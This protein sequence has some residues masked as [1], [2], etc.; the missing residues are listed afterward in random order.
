M[1]LTNI[2]PSFGLAL[3]LVGLP[4]PAMAQI[5]G[6]RMLDTQP[7]LNPVENVVR[8]V[9]REVERQLEKEVLPG[10]EPNAVVEEVT[11]VLDPLAELP[12]Q[13][14]ILNL[15]GAQVFVD[16]EVEDGWRAVERQWLVMLE[17]GELALLQ[18]LDIEILEQTQ[19]DGLGLSLLR[20]RVADDL[21]SREALRQVLPTNLVDRFDRNHIYNPQA[22]KD[23]AQQQDSLISSLCE[24]SLKVGMIDTAIQ[25]QHPAFKHSRITEHNFLGEEFDQPNGHGTAVAGLLVGSDHDSPARLPQATLYNASVFYTRSQYAQG[26]TMMHLVSGL[27]WLMQEDVSVINMS[28]A[29]P[30]NQI[31]AAVV[32]RVSSRGKVIVAAAGNEGPA[33]PPLYPAAYP[34]VISATAVDSE[35]KIYRWANRGDHVDFAAIGVSVLTARGDGKFGRESGTSMAAPVVSAF[36]ACEL[37]DNNGEVTKVIESLVNKAVDLGDTG[38]DSVFGYGLLR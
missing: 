37:A 11:R 22:A 38:R 23:K 31:L 7:L 33:S 3:L 8:Q 15:N 13:L 28:L 26:A 20:F 30:D 25:Q 34:Q 35:E 6:D 27:N 10:V 14:P 16:T 12:K 9:E 32:E 21:N 4:H 29:G 18:Q 36:V 19:Y 1:K 17:P 2:P 24:H 5:L